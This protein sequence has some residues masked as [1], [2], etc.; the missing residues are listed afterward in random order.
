MNSIDDLDIIKITLDE[1]C[2]KI[3]YADVRV[4]IRNGVADVESYTSP[5]T[6]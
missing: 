3:R 2:D 1:N 6:R 5:K 4:I